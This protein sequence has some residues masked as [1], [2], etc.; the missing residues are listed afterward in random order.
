MQTCFK[1][2]GLT[3]VMFLLW[4][5]VWKPFVEMHPYTLICS[6]LSSQHAL[7]PSNSLPQQS[8]INPDYLFR[9]SLSLNEWQHYTV[10]LLLYS[11]QCQLYITSDGKDL[12]S[13]KIQDKSI[14]ATEETE[15]NGGFDKLLQV[16]DKV[17]LLL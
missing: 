6:L 4:V 1:M 13:W 17:V 11:Y 8:S 7:C 3:W 2:S 12:I 9:G 16:T 15:W 14:V 10:N 5:S